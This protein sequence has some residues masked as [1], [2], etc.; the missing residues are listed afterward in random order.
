MNIDQVTLNHYKNLVF[1]FSFPYSLNLYAIVFILVYYVFAY[2]YLLH[3]YNLNLQKE[4]ITLFTPPSRVTTISW[5]SLIFLAKIVI[6]LF[7]IQKPLLFSNFLLR[8]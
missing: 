8:I 2:N 7:I 5:I 1:A 6:Y 4:T 3:S